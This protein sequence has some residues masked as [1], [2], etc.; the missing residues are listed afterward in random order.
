M[1]AA[2]DVVDVV[3]TRLVEDAEVDNVLA[4]EVVFEKDVEDEDT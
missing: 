3:D 1:L 2:D 4:L